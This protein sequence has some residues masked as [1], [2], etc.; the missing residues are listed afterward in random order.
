MSALVVFAGEAQ[1]LITD[2]S[3]E[4]NSPAWVFNGDSG[5]QAADGLDPAHTGSYEAFVNIDNSGVVSQ[6]V[7]TVPGQSYLVDFWIAYNGASTPDSSVSV[8]FGSTVG[9]VQ[10][11][12]SISKYSY[13][14]YFEE[15]FT[16]VATNTTTVFAFSGNL[17]GGTFFLDDVSVTGPSITNSPPPTVNIQKAVYLTSSN[18]WT[19][20]NYQ[21]QASSDLVNWTNQGS[22]FTAT[23][24]SW[25]STQYWNV[26]DWNQL[27]FRLQSLP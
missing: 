14:E 2:P 27:Y 16:A 6:S 11:A 3:F 9:F 13:F 20:S 12:G 10:T 23:N 17:D 7:N 4:L 5:R 22:V 15:S 8:S 21:I 24:S 25:S 18:L 19:G 1:N 26:S